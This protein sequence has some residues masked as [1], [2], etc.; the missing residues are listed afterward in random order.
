MV[1]ATKDDYSKEELYKNILKERNSSVFP[2]RKT[3]GVSRCVNAT[4]ENITG[5]W[6]KEEA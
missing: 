6:F 4:G 1:S 2:A 5:N 3:Q